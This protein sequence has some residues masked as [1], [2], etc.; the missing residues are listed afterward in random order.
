MNNPYIPP[1][2]DLPD[3]P[4]DNKVARRVR[5]LAMAALGSCLTF[6]V[7]TILLVLIVSSFV[8]DFRPEDPETGA[9]AV[10]ATL[11]GFFFGTP[12]VVSVSLIVGFWVMVTRRIKD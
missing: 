12:V 3:Q 8:T 5:R 9:R 10:S 11:Q 7:G 6:L 4:S 2:K 1:E